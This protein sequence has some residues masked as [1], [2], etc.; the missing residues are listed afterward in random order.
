MVARHTLAIF[1]MFSLL[2]N[3][4]GDFCTISHSFNWC[5]VVVVGCIHDSLICLFTTSL[6]DSEYSEFFAWFRFTGLITALTVFFSAALQLSGRSSYPLIFFRLNL[7]IDRDPTHTVGGGACYD[8]YFFPWLLL[9]LRFALT[10][11]AT[12]SVCKLKS[13][14]PTTTPLG[15]RATFTRHAY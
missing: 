12:L 6:N 15:S 4:Q 7:V 9:S 8:R 13:A 10:P 5:V 1:A 14:A 11:S 3:Q 2:C